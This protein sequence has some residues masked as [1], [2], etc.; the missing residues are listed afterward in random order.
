MNFKIAK[1]EISRIRPMKAL[2][3][4][5]WAFLVFSESP[6]AVSQSKAPQTKKAK[7]K[8][9]AMT[10]VKPHRVAMMLEKETPADL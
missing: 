8:I 5:F 7:T 9:P 10:R 2:V 3:M 4:R 6:P 1:V